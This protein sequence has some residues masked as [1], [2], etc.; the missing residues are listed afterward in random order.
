MP[1]PAVAEAQQE[2]PEQL[3]LAALVVVVLL[4]LVVALEVL[5]ALLE[6]HWVVQAAPVV[7]EVLLR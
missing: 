5:A 7:K 1:A 3:M 2:H 4:V 6:A